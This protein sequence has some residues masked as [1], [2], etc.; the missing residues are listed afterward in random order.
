M[1]GRWTIS[2]KAWTRYELHLFR[3]NFKKL[4]TKFK[5]CQCEMHVNFFNLV[6]NFLKLRLKR[7]RSHD[8]SFAS[9]SSSGEQ[10]FDISHH[11]SNISSYLLP[12]TYWGQVLW[13]SLGGK[14]ILSGQTL[15][16]ATER[17]VF[18]ITD[19]SEISVWAARPETLLGGLYLSN[20]LTD[21][22]AVFFIG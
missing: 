20:H 7:C 3:H 17:N 4:K 12:Y 14:K 11:E 15:L 19:K 13:R 21:S 18:N 6:F 16:R 10:Y 2:F 9:T 8:H 1:L 5:R 22:L